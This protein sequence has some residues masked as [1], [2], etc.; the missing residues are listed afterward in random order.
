MQGLKDLDLLEAYMGY[1]INFT[2]KSMP[3]IEEASK[4]LIQGSIIM[5]NMGF[6]K[7]NLEIENKTEPLP[8]YEIL[9][10]REK[11]LNDEQIKQVLNNYK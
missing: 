5:Q 11:G 7:P 9:K 4:L 10:Y 6:P 2:V 8:F 1:W 3:E